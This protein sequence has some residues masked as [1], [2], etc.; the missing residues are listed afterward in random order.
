MPVISGEFAARPSGMMCCVIG[1]GPGAVA[2][3][4]GLIATWRQTIVGDRKSWVL[5]AHGTCV[6]LSNPADD[7]VAQAV[8]ILREYGPVHVGSPAGDFGTIDLSAV[9]GWAVYCHHPD[10]LTYVAPDEVASPVT[11][12]MIGLTGRA[13]RD[14]DG[15][16]LTVVHVEDKRS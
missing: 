6:V 4:D 8:G 5:F 2:D 11:D 12:I 14:R 16:E 7:L 15:R 3:A 1:D 13:K 10:V 9:P